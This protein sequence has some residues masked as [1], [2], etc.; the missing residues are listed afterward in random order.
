[1]LNN[2]SICIV[3]P[4]FNAASTLEQT[5]REI[6]KDIVDNIIL[7]DDGSTDQTSQVALELGLSPVS[8]TRNLGYGANQKT[9]YDLA[10][11]SGADIV[12][13]LHPDYQYSP[14]LIPALASLIAFGDRFPHPGNGCPDRGYA[15]L[16][17]R[18]QPY[19]DLR[20]EHPL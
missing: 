1:M 19:F 10:L 16:Q 20:A 12:V 9:C 7:V 6:P 15:S 17:V 3:M 5:F 11:K 18:E 4:A 14:K 13:M 2:Q 8:H